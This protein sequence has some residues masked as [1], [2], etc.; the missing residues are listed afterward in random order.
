MLTTQGA[1]HD[2]QRSL[3]DFSCPVLLATSQKPRKIHAELFKAGEGSNF[4]PTRQHLWSEPIDVRTQALLAVAAKGPLPALIAVDLAGW[5]ALANSQF[6]LLMPDFCSSLPG[7]WMARGSVGVVSALIL[8]PP[9]Q[10]IMS[11]L[12]AMMTPLLARPIAH[13]EPQSGALTR[14]GDRAFCSD[15]RRG[16]AAGRLRSHGY[17]S[18]P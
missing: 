6:S 15:L 14:A 8:N 3:S 4:D 2:L 1:G 10:L 9:A 7:D 13:L 11:C 16:M 17:R 18:C 12:M 5:V